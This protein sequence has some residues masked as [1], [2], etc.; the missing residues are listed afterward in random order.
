VSNPQAAAEASHN[1]W[2]AISRGRPGSALAEYW[3]DPGTALTQDINTLRTSSNPLVSGA[4]RL[5]DSSPAGAVINP[6]TSALAGNLVGGMAH[7][8]VDEGNRYGPIANE[9][10]VPGGY[11]ANRAMGITDPF[12]NVE[13][14]YHHDGWGTA[15]QDVSALAAVA[16]GA[17]GLARAG[18]AEGAAGGAVRGVI[19]KSEPEAVVRP[20][21]VGPGR[22]INRDLNKPT[23]QPNNPAG[24]RPLGNAGQ[25]PSNRSGGGTDRPPTG[26]ANSRQPRDP[27]TGNPNSSVPGTDPGNRRLAGVAAG[28]KGADASA[29]SVD[30]P[31]PG[32][33][34]PTSNSGSGAKADAAKPP[35]DSPI[36]DKPTA[37]AGGGA[38][39]SPP[40]D[41]GR[42][43]TPPKGASNAGEESEDS[44]AST[45]PGQLATPPNNSIDLTKFNARISLQRQARHLA[46]SD[47]T[48]RGG[49][50]SSVADAQKVLDAF[51]AGHTEIIGIT[52]A[53]NMA[54]RYGRVTGFNNNIQKGFVDQPTH[55]FV[56]KGSKSPSVVPANPNGVP[57]AK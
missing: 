32:T 36:E 48:N 30:R 52:P 17:G 26:P 11:A 27:N 12:A 6:Y 39:T 29:N 38:N 25:G 55:V 2:D 37:A 14:D 35:N 5:L 22:L 47:A 23:T 15:A 21:S 16:G 3:N 19:P 7:L 31:L 43:T 50:M 1:R 4:T 51:R 24:N 34:K 46:G 33:N 45:K 10:V 57:V 18:P 49:Y 41:P 53:G 13:N 9:Y 44:I 42:M 28:P 8:V 40:N 56:I 20:R 54:V